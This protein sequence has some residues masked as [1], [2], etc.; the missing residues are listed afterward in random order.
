MNTAQVTQ[1]LDFGVIVRLV[2]L[3]QLSL[4]HDRSHAHTTISA[5][6]TLHFS[7]F[8]RTVARISSILIPIFLPIPFSFCAALPEVTSPSCRRKADAARKYAIAC[9]VRGV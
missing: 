4:R 3:V 2:E 8:Q 1:G 7:Q 9:H 6:I 5:A